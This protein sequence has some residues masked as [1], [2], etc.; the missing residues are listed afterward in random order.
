MA[1]LIDQ[2]TNDICPIAAFTKIKA[3]VLMMK[4][5]AVASLALV[6]LTACA[7]APTQS[8]YTGVS[9]PIAA[10]RAAGFFQTVCVNNG[11]DLS[12][13]R[14]TLARLPVVLNSDSD[15]Y[16]G[17]EFLL[18]FKITPVSRFETVCSMVWDPI[19]PNEQAMAVLRGLDP[20]AQVRDND[21]GTISA[22]HYGAP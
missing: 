20:T 18:S 7:Q 4:R 14:Q 17:T 16:H 13:A 19:D 11:A 2:R 3:Q 10:S 12:E 9:Q 21:D 8:G 22:F 15:I 5:F 6:T 1:S